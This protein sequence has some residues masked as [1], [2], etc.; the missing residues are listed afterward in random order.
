MEP[1]PPLSEIEQYP[2]FIE[3]T[4][5]RKAE[6]YDNY[7]KRRKEEAVNE[8]DFN[9]LLKEQADRNRN[10]V[11]VQIQV[12]HPFVT[13]PKYFPK[14]LQD[15]VQSIYAMDQEFKFNQEEAKVEQFKAP[16]MEDP[17][18]SLGVKPY[19]YN[20]QQGYS[21]RYPNGDVES[22]PGI[23]S[24]AQ[25]TEYL[26][27]K[28]D[29]F[30]GKR[31]GVFDKYNPLAESELEGVINSI[32]KVSSGLEGALN[33]SIKTVQSMGQGLMLDT[34]DEIKKAANRYSEAES[35][36]AQLDPQIAAEER[37]INEFGR[38]DKM[39]LAELKQ[40]RDAAAAIVA[41]D[42]GQSYESIAP[43]LKEKYKELIDSLNETSK[44]GGAE[45]LDTYNKY[46]ESLP[47]DQRGTASAFSNYFRDKPSQLLPYIATTA[48]A[49][50][51][52]IAAVMGS[53]LAAGA[54][55]GPTA[56]AATGQAVGFTREY[57]ATLM[58]EMQLRAARENK[59]LTPEI[60]N[61]YMDNPLFMDK[62][63][64]MAEVRGAVIGGADAVLG[65]AA[66][67]VV[68]SAVTGR[69]KKALLGGAIGVFTEGT[70][71][72][73]AQVASGQKTNFTEIFNEAIGGI[74]ATAVSV[75]AIIIDSSIKARKAAKTQ[76]MVE[77]VKQRVE[78]A[79]FFGTL[80][81]KKTAEQR[82]QEMKDKLTPVPRVP[83]PTAF[84]GEV[85]APFVGET[86]TGLDGKQ[87]FPKAAQK[88]FAAQEQKPLGGQVQ[89][90]FVGETEQ[91][92]GEETPSVGTP[93]A[94]VAPATLVT[95][96][97]PAAPVTPTA[98]PE[99][100]APAEAPSV[101]PAP[102]QVAPTNPMAE[103]AP[104]Q[105]APVQ[106]TQSTE[107][108]PVAETPVAPVVGPTATTPS[109]ETA[110]APQTESTDPNAGRPTLMYFGKEMPYSVSIKQE[111]GGFK[112]KSVKIYLE[113]GMY[114]TVRI[115]KE[116][117]E[118]GFAT[119]EEAEAAGPKLLAEAQKKMDA[120][121]QADKTKPTTKPP[122]GV[123]ING[124]RYTNARELIESLDAEYGAALAK[125][126]DAN[127]AIK[128]ALENIPVE[129]GNSPYFDGKKIVLSSTANL[130][131]TKAHELTHAILDVA[132]DTVNSFNQDINNLMTDLIKD[133]S[134]VSKR[135]ADIIEKVRSLHSTST[136]KLSVAQYMATYI[137]YIFDV[138]GQSQEFK[139]NPL[140]DAE[141]ER[142]YAFLSPHEFLA[143]IMSDPKFR[144]TLIGK[145]ITP[146][147]K[148]I[149]TKIVDAIKKLFGKI[150]PSLPKNEFEKLISIIENAVRN[151]VYTPGQ[152]KRSYNRDGSVNLGNINKDSGATNALDQVNQNTQLTEEDQG[153]EINKSSQPVITRASFGDSQIYLSFDASGPKTNVEDIK[154]AFS[155]EDYSAEVTE[156]QSDFVSA[157]S[158][159]AKYRIDIFN[160]GNGAMSSPETTRKA[161]QN[162]FGTTERI[163]NKSV[164]ELQG[165][166]T[167]RFA[168][169]YESNVFNPAGQSKNV[170]NG[171]E[172]T[173]G[174]THALGEVNQDTKDLASVAVTAEEKETVAKQAERD[175]AQNRFNDLKKEYPEILKDTEFDGTNLQQARE[176]VTEFLEASFDKVDAEGKEVSDA[177]K[178]QGAKLQVNLRLALGIL[179]EKIKETNM[180]ES[181][182]GYVLDAMEYIVD[183][184]QDMT[185]MT[186]NKMRYFNNVLASF[187][188]GGA[189]VGMK[190]VITKT[191]ISKWKGI[192]NEVIGKGAIFDKP[193][194][195][196]R[197]SPLLGLFAGSLGTMATVAHEVA[198]IG[199]NEVAHGFIRDLMG[200]FK[201]NID[202]KQLEETAAIES[203]YQHL[204]KVIPKISNQS[205]HMIGI[206]AM[207]TQWDKA[208]TA[209]PLEQMVKRNTQLTDSFADADVVA[210]KA[211]GAMLAYDKK[212]AAIVKQAYDAL[213]SGIDL[214]S[215]P[216]EAAAIAAI[217]AR[218]SPEQLSVLNKTR[219]MGKAF[220]PFLKNV[221]AVTKNVNLQ[222][223]QNYVHDSIIT[224]SEKGERNNV[225]QSDSMSDVLHDRKGFDPT[226][227]YPETSI[228]AIT[229]SQAKSS[230]Y[231][232]H[233]G[234]E[235]YLFRQLMSD[236]AFT[237]LLNGFDN[238][239]GISDRLIKIAEVYNESMTKNQPRAGPVISLLE[240]IG[241]LVMSSKIFGGD[242][243]IKN[244]TGGLIS[245][246]T[247][248]GLDAQALFDGI[249]Y[250]KNMGKI[251]DFL[252]KNV[253]LQYN[254][255]SQFDVIEGKDDRYTFNNKR[256]LEKELGKHW[257]KAFLNAAPH[258]PQS[259]VNVLQKQVFSRL[260]NYSN[261]LPERQSAFAIWTAAY[262]HYAKKNGTVIDA[263]DFIAR[264]P[265]DKRAANDANDFTTTAMGYAPD[266]AGKG[267]F[268]NGSTRAK[269]VLSK[270]LFGF[271]QQ[272]TGLAVTAQNEL[273]K[274]QRLFRSGNYSEGNK[275][276]LKSSV[277]MGNVLVFRKM[278]L[279]LQGIVLYPVLTQY[280]NGSDDEE[281]KKAILKVRKQYKDTSDR[282][283]LGALYKDMASVLFPAFGAAPLL[284][285]SL[286]LLADGLGVVAS[287]QEDGSLME[288]EFKKDLKVQS[289][290]IKE[291]LDVLDKKIKF[292]EKMDLQDRPE[293]E[294]M[295][296]EEE[297]LMAIKDE[298]AGKLKFSY[299][300]A[301]KTKAAL[302]PYGMYG[303]LGEFVIKQMQSFTEDDLTTE[304]QIE[305]GRLL[306]EQ[307]TYNDSLAGP[308]FL[309]GMIEQPYSILR[310]S[311]MGEMGKAR[312]DRIPTAV[313]ILKQINAGQ[314]PGV[315]LERA[316]TEL[317]KMIAK[318]NVEHNRKVRELQEKLK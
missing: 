36:I 187:A 302:S 78:A 51:P 238:S 276:L 137:N 209:S 109:T 106:E 4:P 183:S 18:R 219:D 168:Q 316:R 307:V 224:P 284:T 85:E 243:F 150:G 180:T 143:A 12:N 158:G 73:L 126:L 63:R 296:K 250:E 277:A 119:I 74:G 123:I 2:E 94:P 231:E 269:Q 128:K 151:P 30:D 5:E 20:G 140:T 253:P 282:S 52:D 72:G 270:T 145:K 167:D 230:T 101:G 58:S 193:I 229:E 45:V 80:K 166:L 161:Y 87:G 54:I 199:T 90:P 268:W 29:K 191:F 107:N 79:K 155:G 216:D 50:A 102:E 228:R 15:Q 259:A 185:N 223:Y 110:P 164:T 317:A 93:T 43:V 22:V 171:I 301:D 172:T 59:E 265:Y 290:E 47:E 26:K 195:I 139:N 272:S 142:A 115:P 258:L 220:L 311:Y 7:F 245:R 200:V 49:A 204:N 208:A 130:E 278:T 299:V 247:L 197:N 221:K 283:N 297:K 303:M 62:V 141:L 188:D 136:A 56:A 198:Y 17:N 178:V 263:D 97:A 116:L 262:I 112:V 81:D 242:P 285:G 181:Q 46:I 309:N 306:K 28:A 314:D 125:I 288:F 88:P 68:E 48:I 16:D 289:T 120:E 315:I 205:D 35:T 129:P 132:L 182:V 23:A 99:Q 308:G 236:P 157:T 293:F 295:L 291:Q 318:K 233:T 237:N 44:I 146:E 266:K 9:M 192:L 27:T 83:D 240:N 66:Q 57:T 211:K 1:L 121:V 37:K 77:M 152:Y 206:A 252:K 273:M 8:D 179:P 160:K 225:K 254:R 84:E 14:E 175:I 149:I 118:G 312:E 207:L 100:T 76:E 177:K 170:L 189:L 304:E 234:V 64:T 86:A 60:L 117:Q 24:K 89:R 69:V 113:N 298:I 212:Q 244:A 227:A 34:I 6:V 162:A 271:M 300:T 127:P 255:T 210:N 176:K 96:T 134:V 159:I 163:A 122:S 232:K 21:I 239:S 42:K 203:W 260:S 133:K 19:K 98:A 194:D 184:T 214:A 38:G 310:K 279:I 10:S 156:F 70:G 267:S 92:F 274:S 174:I 13:D 257:F 154:K 82:V 261:A 41:S 67:K 40:E 201:D 215:F 226:K 53:S 153:E 281:K 105:A 264:M 235:R 218:L 292:A 246:L 3:A 305:M 71:E 144:N 103:T 25:L 186:A 248:G 169:V 11:K 286:N 124:V 148:S 196:R 256:R 55:G 275:A 251:N 95:P 241:A 75:P 114:D 33:Q 91:A 165:S 65:G 111:G 61:S 287:T 138:L 173:A 249:V 131:I 213:M 104:E 31:E 294:L 135:V 108:T 217:E 222:D 202:F 147:R 190:G 39:R 280:F 313:S 32:N